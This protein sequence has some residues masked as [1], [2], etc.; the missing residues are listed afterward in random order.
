MANLTPKQQ[1]FAEE[2]LVDFNA[3]KAAQRAGYSE[4]T[5][6][7]QGQRLL[8][9]VEICEFIENARAETSE[10]L[11]ITRERLME[12]SI[13]VYD[14]AIADNQLG[15][16]NGAIKE[17]GILSGERVE[18]QEQ[19]VITHEERLAAARERVNAARQ[20]PTIN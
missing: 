17:L 11:E 6:Y 13:T 2:Y 16:A 19:T 15:A 10:K 1:R 20:R 7:S 18:K 4:K 5:A 8:K 3:T 9:N 12:M 14:A